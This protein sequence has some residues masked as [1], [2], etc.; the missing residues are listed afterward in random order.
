MDISTYYLDDRQMFVI[1]IGEKFDFTK[2][3]RFRQAYQHVDKTVKHIAVDLQHTEYMD[4]SALGMLLSMQKSFAGRPISF[5]IENSRPAI[6]R[7]LKIS[8]F[9]KKFILR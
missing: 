1:D 8:R 3:E 4:S 7:I 9:D 5:S 2:V 6:A